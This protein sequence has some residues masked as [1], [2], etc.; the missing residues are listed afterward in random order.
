MSNTSGPINYATADT[1]MFLM[2]GM[3]RRTTN[4]LLSVRRGIWQADTQ[5]GHDPNGRVLGILGM[6]EFGT[7]FAKWAQAFGMHCSI[8]RP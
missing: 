8:L 2:L 1:A 5:V 7:E 4:P 6:G 3:L